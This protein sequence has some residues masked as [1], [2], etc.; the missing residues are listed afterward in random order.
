MAKVTAKLQVT[1][2]KALADRYGIAPG[3]DIDWEAAGD[4]IRVVPSRRRRTLDPRQ[5]L[6]L[7]DQATARQQA[8]QKRHPRQR[9]RERGWTRAD[10]YDRGRAR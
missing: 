10:L 7:F 3:D 6:R 1:V 4:V 5:R 9:V 2:P 8:R